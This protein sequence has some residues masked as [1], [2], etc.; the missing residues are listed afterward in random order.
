MELDDRESLMRASYINLTT[1]GRKSGEPRTVELSFALKGNEVL[2][3]AGDGGK[4]QWYQNLLADPKVSIR[5]GNISLRGRAVK[6]ISHPKKLAREILSLFREKY[7]SAYVRDWY[8][9]TDRAPVRIQVLGR[10]LD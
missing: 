8:Q 7:G 3:L 6:R 10:E 5:V 4:V 9:G 1:T 2:C